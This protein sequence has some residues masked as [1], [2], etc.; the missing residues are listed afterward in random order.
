MSARIQGVTPQE[1]NGIHF[2]STLERDT[3]KALTDMGIPFRYEEV[4]F[5]LLDGFYSAYQKEKVRAITY[6]PDFLIGENILIECKGFETPEWKLK[7]KYIYKYLQENEPQMC[8]YQIHDARKSL[9]EALDGHWSYLG[10]AV[11]VTPK[12]KKKNSAQNDSPI[13]YD[14][15]H[16]AMEALNIHGSIG[17]I[18]RSLTNQT[19]YTYGYKWK[20]I[21]LKI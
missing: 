20:I 8:F 7:K 19:A 3:A 4:K 2:R 18:F 15:L 13:L 11:Q 5:K 9:L 12:P 1:W 6:T 21:K 14:S 17:T 10:C 16:Q